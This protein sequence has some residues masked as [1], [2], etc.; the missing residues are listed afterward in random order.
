MSSL[1]S[2]K[3][4]LAPKLHRVIE[5]LTAQGITM[6]GNLLYGLLCVRLLS[7][8]DYAKFA[9]VFGFLGTLTML[10]DIN[11]SGTLIPLIGE[12]ID[13]R[14]LIA[15]YVA[16][17]R[18]LARQL[19]WLIAPLAVLTYPLLVHKQQWSWQVVAAMIAILLFAAWFARL[20]GA[21]GAVLIVRRDRGYWY[22]SQMISSLG[23]LA[24]LLVL[25][26]AHWLNAFSAILLNVAGILFVSQSYYL[27]AGK[28]LGVTG[29][30]SKEKRAAIVHLALPNMPNGIFF[31][32]QGQISLFL[33]TLFGH[34]AAVASVGALGRLA[35]I[36]ALFGQMNPLL[37]EPYFAKLPQS[38]VKAN[39]VGVLAL[40]GILCLVITGLA[41]YF[42]LVFLWVLGPKYAGLHLEV[43]LIVATSSI[44]Y[45]CGVL[46]VIHSS[47]RYVY[48]WNGMMTI[49]LT[50]IVQVIFI[51]KV[52]L[53]TVRAV[54]ALNLAMA[55][56]SLLVNVLTGI[57]GFM[58]GPRKLGQASI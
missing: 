39:Y 51:W 5:F 1:R 2:W 24:L 16:S 22:R 21:Y 20:S 14:Q 45:L 12:R 36:F 25:W 26:F 49:T 42:P 28:L 23:T 52:D 33:I 17:L 41:R 38:R 3:A 53:S 55:V 54:L 13:D 30:P 32:L 40:E 9:V 19:Y 10:M 4:F 50:L 58:R 35:Q 6:A 8:A 43:L 56:V 27:R 18:Q 37:L 48:W 57:Y 11:F 15:D 47:R 34:T 7:L 44:G 29:H 31:A 46:W